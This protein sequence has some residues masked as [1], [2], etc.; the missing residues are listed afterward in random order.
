MEVVCNLRSKE[1]VMEDKKGS[2]N[3]LKSSLLAKVHGHCLIHKL[4]LQEFHC[5]NFF[6][7]SYSAGDFVNMT[8]HF[9]EIN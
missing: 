5:L 3:D 4:Q 1:N 8:V 2:S 7:V 6:L 9:T